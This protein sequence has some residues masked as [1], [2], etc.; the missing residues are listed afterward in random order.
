MIIKV[1]FKSKLIL[2]S[3][4]E[5]IYKIKEVDIEIGKIQ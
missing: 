5:F 2:T 1:C 3:T 4:A